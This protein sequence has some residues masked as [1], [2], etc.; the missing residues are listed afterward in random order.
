MQS[1][2]ILPTRFRHGKLPKRNGLRSL[3][4]RNLVPQ[5]LC[6]E[7]HQ[8]LQ[9]PQSCIERSKQ[10]LPCH[11]SPLAVGA[12]QFRLDPLDVPVTE[13]APEKLIHGLRRLVKAVSV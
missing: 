3:R 6:Q 1:I 8:R 13:V 10:V 7:R 4:L 2:G 9:Q 5:L 12:L 11:R